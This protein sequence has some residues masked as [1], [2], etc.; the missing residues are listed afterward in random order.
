MD[1]FR[2]TGIDEPVFVQKDSKLLKTKQ[3][4]KSG[5]THPYKWVA[6]VY[7]HWS[8]YPFSM[9]YENRMSFNV[10]FIFIF[11][12][13]CKVVLKCLNL[14]KSADT[15]HLGQSTESSRSDPEKSKFQFVNSIIS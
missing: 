5:K 12:V 1:A 14:F 4:N 3:N 2:L 6:I 11:T 13:H 10:I 15:L 8:K 9:F 7:K